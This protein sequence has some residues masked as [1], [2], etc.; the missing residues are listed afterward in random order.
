MFIADKHISLLDYA[1]RASQK[2]NSIG[3]QEICFNKQTLYQKHNH[4]TKLILDD[5]I[6]QIKNNIDQITLY[7]NMTVILG[8]NYAI[9]EHI[10]LPYKKTKVGV[11]SLISSKIEQY[12]PLNKN[13]LASDY[14]TSNRSYTTF[15]N[16][17]A[18]NKLIIEN[19]QF[20][21]TQLNLQFKCATIEGQVLCI[22]LQEVLKQYIRNNRQYFT[23]MRAGLLLL[24]CDS[25][26]RYILVDHNKPLTISFISQVAIQENTNIEHNYLSDIVQKFSIDYILASN[27]TGSYINLTT[28]KIRHPIMLFC[29]EDLLQ[30]CYK[31]MKSTIPLQPRHLLQTLIL[32]AAK[33]LY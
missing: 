3:H 31:I 23:K 5:L 32:L 10:E 4:A 16:L 8:H 21:A 22:G 20:V 29:L 26:I 15:I 25:Y 24:E 12:T 2:H 14:T 17:Y 11:E 7:K 19:L 1:S 28:L 30:L 9:Q 27:N 13:E 18:C 33:N 6:Q